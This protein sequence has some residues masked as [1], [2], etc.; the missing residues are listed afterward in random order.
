MTYLLFE[1]IFFINYLW[2][3]SYIDYNDYDGLILM[4]WLLLV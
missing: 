2:F 3:Q 1:V 4:K